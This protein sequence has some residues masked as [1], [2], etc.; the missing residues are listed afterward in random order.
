[1]DD[2]QS[3][4]HTSTTISPNHTPS[5]L[6]VTGQSPFAFSPTFDLL[7]PGHSGFSFDYPIEKSPPDPMEI[8]PEPMEFQYPESSSSRSPLSSAPV[9]VVADQLDYNGLP[10]DQQLALQQLM[11]NIAMY[12]QRFGIE[13][14]MPAP[15]QNTI[16]P[17]KV[18][19]TSPPNMFAFPSA[20]PPSSSLAAAPVPAAEPHEDAHDE[21]DE[22][23]RSIRQGSSVS[24][25]GDHLDE[26]LD[27]LVPLPQIF[28][29]GRGKGGKKG[30][31]MSSVVRGDD[32]EI[33][34]DDNW[35][36]SPEEY[37]KLSSKEKR[38]L[39]NK[40]SARAFRT[41][42]KDYIGTL[43]GHIQDRDTVIDAIRSELSSSRA[44]TQD[45]RCVSNQIA[46]R[47]R[48]DESRH[49]KELAALKAS[50]MSV[51]HPETAHEESFP[52]ALVSA[53]TMSP[54]LPAA[55]STPSAPR[56]A[57]TPITI[58]TRKDLSASRES[59]RGFWGGSDPSS[60]GG[61]ST[62]CHTMFTPDLVLPPSPTSPIA[63]IRSFADKPRAN[64]NPHL[65][66]SDERAPR[67]SSPAN[68]REMGAPFAEWS[69]STPFTLRSMDSY[70]MQMWSRLARAA[71]A[72]KSNVSA[73]LRPK[74]FVEAKAS[75]STSTTISTADAAILAAAA[76]S[77]ITS[78]LTSSFWSA[79]AGPGSILDA[80]KL[81]AVVIGSAKLKVV[82]M[83]EKNGQEDESE[84]L[85][86]ALSSLRLHA[87][88]KMDAMRARE[89]PLGTIGGFFKMSNPMPT[90]A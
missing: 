24:S 86:S 61:G 16:E 37:K 59:S 77:H 20:N 65:D 36:P 85:T 29:A 80:D 64:I 2:E 22:P 44:E 30:G 45:L 18:F 19:S 69:E 76:T 38:Q 42:R 5:P 3:Q 88:V 50:T 39:R 84:G 67:L 28:S 31:G 74:F 72:E 35:R 89:N 26:R 40:L 34:D 46:R 79:F 6:A 49:R 70:R 60:F 52:P 14:T 12:Q 78:Q 7:N 62:I 75:A 32:E 55:S 83:N 9:N 53:F 4:T 82:E 33:D 68:G 15:Q 51:L 58:N 73:D 71:A 21:H 48:T 57:P 10:L 47:A 25:F 13:Q 87:G 54:S 81:A 27:R 8:K 43:E 11:T 63:S 90:R 41:R 66:E 17:S 1:M 23:L 56:R